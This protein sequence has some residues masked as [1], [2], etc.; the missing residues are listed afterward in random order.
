[1]NKMA[2]FVEGYTELVFVDRLI[3]EIASQNAI[4]IAWRVIRGGTNTRRTSR[5]IKT[6][7]PGIKSDH[8]VLLYDCG[9][10]A[11][12]KTRM[13]EEYENLSA[14]QYS[15]IVCI[16]DVYP[17]FLHAEIPELESSLP[18]YVKIKPIIVDFVLSIMEI[19]A[20][21]LRECS[22]FPRIDPQI[23]LPKIVATLGF[24]PQ[25]E[26]M[27]L[28]TSPCDDL[29]N[30]YAL[31]GKAYSK[32]DAQTTIDALDFAEIYLGL[33]EKIP[34]LKKHCHC[35]ESFLAEAGPSEEE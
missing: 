2:I 35:I 13:R 7:Q 5:W 1:M 9:G 30:V 3:Q 20:W 19:E 29:R 26:D 10:D 28:R 18:K 32:G 24:N 27:S 11:A 6:I 33:T 17:S 21:F 23:T 15:R 4:Q 25:D 8:Y 12:V 22:H 16:R 14:A 34:Y 31:G